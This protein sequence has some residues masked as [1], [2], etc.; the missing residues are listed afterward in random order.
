MARIL[1]IWYEW[2]TQCSDPTADPQETE[3][4]RVCDGRGYVCQELGARTQ[5]MVRDLALIGQ[6]GSVSWGRVRL[7][8]L[9]KSLAESSRHLVKVQR[10]DVRTSQREGGNFHDVRLDAKLS[11]DHQTNDCG[12]VDENNRNRSSLD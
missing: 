4:Q 2:P 9:N 8:G 1:N 7:I 11:F 12:A 3:L 6:S 5:A 10:Q